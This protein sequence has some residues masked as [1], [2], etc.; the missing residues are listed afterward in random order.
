ME[1]KQRIVFRNDEHK[2]LINYLIDNGIEFIND[3]QTSL[4]I[5]EILETHLCWPTIN[6][7]I[8]QH[9]MITIAD[10]I[11]TKEELDQAKWFTIR[12][13][14]RWQYPQPS[15]NGAYRHI[16]YSNQNTCIECGS[17]EIQID[18]FRLKMAP[19][20]GKRH[21]LMLNWIDDELFSSDY[22]RSVLSDSGL[23][24]LSFLD[25]LKS[26]NRE[27]MENINQL[28]I[29]HILPEGL[30]D[31]D[32]TIKEITTCKICGVKKYVMAGRGLV[33]KKSVF[34]NDV[35]IAKS[36]EVF[37][38]GHYAPQCI[39]VNRRFYD[40]IIINGLDRNLVFEPLKLK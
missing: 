16:T 1:I 33:Y 22:A 3:D 36:F 34:S 8:I 20:W 13:Q 9:N 28:K 17:N 6:D 35:D 37:G 32:N 15:Q 7:Y 27:K 2:D 26:G 14:W 11:Y 25:A 29:D 19:K 4:I 5:L 30:I 31:Q 24:G 39:F 12:S 38:F 18:L 10:S 21:F 40:I 23:R